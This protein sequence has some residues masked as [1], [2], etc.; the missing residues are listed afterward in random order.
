VKQVELALYYLFG[1]QNFN[2]FFDYKRIVFH[3][4]SVCAKAWPLV[5]IDTLLPLYLM[6]E[7]KHV[8]VFM[9]EAITIRSFVRLSLKE[10]SQR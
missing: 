4:I 7:Q 9:P 6:K 2:Q 1:Y 10:L 5:K 8:R 3:F